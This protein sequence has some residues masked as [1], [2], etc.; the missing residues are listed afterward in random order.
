M[1][2]ES[3]LA[4][5]CEKSYLDQPKFIN[6]PIKPIGFEY[7]TIKHVQA[8][9]VQFKEYNV[10]VF[11]GT[12]S[13]KD[14]QQNLRVKA[15]ETDWL[16]S[17]VYV[18]FYEAFEATWSEYL[19]N[20]D[21]IELLNTKTLYITGH[22]FGGCLAILSALKLK[23]LKPFSDFPISVYTYGTPK[24]LINPNIKDY[25]PIYRYEMQGDIIPHLPLFNYTN[26]GKV[27][28]LNHKYS[29]LLNWIVYSKYWFKLDITQLIRNHQI[30]TYVKLLP[31][32]KNSKTS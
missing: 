31:T 3:L 5:L 32:A 17:S 18:G 21:V 15:V 1:K 8:Y 20:E 27:I 4:H 30:E 19:S 2:I 6:L 22:S 23:S 10:L 11:R 7:F 26:I 24:F 16:A 12:D 9:L 14:W 28:K 29:R 13:I 25:V